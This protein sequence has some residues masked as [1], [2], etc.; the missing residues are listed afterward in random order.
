MVGTPVGVWALY[1]RGEEVGRLVRYDSPVAA[2]PSGADGQRVLF[3]VQNAWG[4]DI[5]LVDALGR[6]WRFRPWSDEPEWVGTGTVIDGARRVLGL[7]EAP[8]AVPHHPDAA[9]EGAPTQSWAAGREVTSIQAPTDPMN[10]LPQPPQ[11]P[12]ESAPTASEEIH[13]SGPHR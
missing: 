3:A 4:Q 1:T 5:G 2:T 11:D 13:D 10:S 12:E 8:R 7:D 6:A 9:P